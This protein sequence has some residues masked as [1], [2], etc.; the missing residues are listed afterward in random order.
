VLPFAEMYAFVVFYPSL[1]QPWPVS[2]AHQICMKML[3]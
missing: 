2:G 3:S 1:L